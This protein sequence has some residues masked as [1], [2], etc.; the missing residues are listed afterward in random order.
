MLILETLYKNIKIQKEE[1]KVK[2]YLYNSNKQK[3]FKNTNLHLQNE[4][5]AVENIG[6]FET[7]EEVRQK[8]FSGASHLLSFTNLH[9]ITFF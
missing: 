7:E 5:N 9:S 3:L 4:I 6:H 1:N 8:L 2:L